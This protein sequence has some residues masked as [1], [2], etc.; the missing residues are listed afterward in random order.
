MFRVS[1]SHFWSNFS[2]ESCLIT[3]ILRHKLGL[4]V[5]IVHEKSPQIDLAVYSVF[6]FKNK[7]DKLGRYGL[8]MCNE[9]RKW[10]YIN[11]ADYGFTDAKK[12]SARKT[13]WYT[14][15]NL[16]VPLNVADA[17][18]SF[19]RTDPGLRNVYFPFFFWR[20]DWGFLA[21]E[22]VK[23]MTPEYLSSPR[24]IENREKTACAFSRTREPSRMRLY[25]LV[26]ESIPLD[27]FGES[28]GNVVS[29]KHRQARQY[30][31]QVC[32][33]ND[34][35]PGYVTEKIPEAWFSGNVPIWQGIDSH[36]LFN[37][38]AIIDVTGLRSED[39]RTILRNINEEKLQVMRRMP[40][41]NSEPILDPVVNLLSELVS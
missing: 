32:P 18:L 11:R 37:Q 35:Y 24:D 14:P 31:L 22:T 4:E 2:P 38:E 8:G 19:D 7:W 33:E 3:Q 5:E 16:R 21:D 39:I 28:K 25:S 41:L 15:E 20:I 34:L 40:I 17:Y 27:I 13:L 26:R 12:S 23:G 1:Y 9:Q 36:N 10:D 6:P 30:G 29:D